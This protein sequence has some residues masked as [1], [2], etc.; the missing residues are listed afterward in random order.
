MR[1]FIRHPLDVPI[2]I[3]SAPDGSYILECTQD[4]SFGGLAFA[5]DAAIEPGRII[6]LRIPY[7]RPVFEVTAAR[8][9][10]CKTTGS[11][12]AVGVEFLDSAEAFRVRMIEQVCHIESYR[13][14]V[15]QRDGRKL[16][17]EEAAA[18]WIS[19]YA[20]SFPTP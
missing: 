17:A 1:Q 14:E 4:V 10:W 20:S 7:F 18:E 11:K 2:E 19:L 8:V 16:T 3:R 5:S 12:Y 6:N 13:R 9:T 15:E